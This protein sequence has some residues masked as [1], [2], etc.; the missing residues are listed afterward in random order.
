MKT[1]YIRLHMI[2]ADSA[3]HALFF[4]LKMLVSKMYLQTERKWAIK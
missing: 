2:N 1:I 3:Q 4:R